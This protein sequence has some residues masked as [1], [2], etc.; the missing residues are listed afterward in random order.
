[1]H[2][3][4][5]Q[6]RQHRE[7]ERLARRKSHAQRKHPRKHGRVERV[8]NYWKR[9]S[10]TRRIIGAAIAIGS[11][12]A[13]IRRYEA[14]KNKLGSEEKTREFFKKESLIQAA[15]QRFRP[16]LRRFAARGR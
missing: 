9:D 5:L 6:M 11:G 15:P 16:M 2:N 14:V 3:L 1:M 12:R 13:L 10:V 7:K 8:K 4:R